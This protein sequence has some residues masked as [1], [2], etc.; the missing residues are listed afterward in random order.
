VS[1]TE[2]QAQRHRPRFIE[3]VLRVCAALGV[4]G[5]LAWG[6]HHEPHITCS[7]RGTAAAAINRCTTTSMTTIAMHWAVALGGG[8]LVGGAVGV[9]VVLML[10]GRAA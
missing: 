1:I 9:G 3:S 10:R 2:S 6:L 8:L 7:A 5:G 4:M